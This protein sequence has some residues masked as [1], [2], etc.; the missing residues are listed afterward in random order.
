MAVTPSHSGICV[1]DLERS[2]RFYCEG[3]GFDAAERL[4]ARGGPDFA[5][6]LEVESDPDFTS[7]FVRSGPCTLELLQYTSPA[8]TGSPSAS[9]GRLGLTHLAFH[10]EDS[11]LAAKRLVELGG[12]RLAAADLMFDNDGVVTT[13][14]GPTANHCIFVADPDGVRIELLQWGPAFEG[15]T[16]M[17][18]EDG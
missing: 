15:T 12:T 3:L 16:W 10:V 6:F 9:R 18:N 2:I 14:A 7:A 1:T 13:G 4:P 5:A 17:P 8:P 11:E